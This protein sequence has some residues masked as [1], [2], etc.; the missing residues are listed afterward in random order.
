M[1]I[2]RTKSGLRERGEEGAGLRRRIDNIIVGAVDEQEAQRIVID[3]GVADRRGVEIRATPDRRYAEELTDSLLFG[4]MLRSCVH[5]G[6][7]GS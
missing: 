4:R 6:R 1:T 2:R 5:C 7:Q 3:C